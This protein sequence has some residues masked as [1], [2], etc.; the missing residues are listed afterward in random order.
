LPSGKG[1]A[2]ALTA[3]DAG[4]GKVVKPNQVIPLDDAEFEDF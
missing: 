3:G 2:L 1:K 4:R